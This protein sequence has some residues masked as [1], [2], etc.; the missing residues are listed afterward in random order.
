MSNTSIYLT[1]GAINPQAVAD[2]IAKQT[3]KTEIGAHAIFLGQVRADI[4]DAKNVKAIEYSAYPEMIES[5]VKNIKDQIYSKYNEIIC[6]YIL[7]SIGLVKAGQLS[8]FVFVGSKHRKQA[9][10]ASEEIVDLIKKDLP[11]WKKELF[12]D[13]TTN[14]KENVI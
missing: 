9:F 8:L 4:V 14:W 12:D 10:M 7:H 2:Y 5:A 3:S 1:E 6:V 11:V 13:G